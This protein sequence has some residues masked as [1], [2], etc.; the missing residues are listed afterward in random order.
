MKRKTVLLLASVLTISLTGCG[1]PLII[2][3]AT[4]AVDSSVSDSAATEADQNTASQQ[5]SAG[6]AAIIGQLTNQSDESEE[7]EEETSEDNVYTKNLVPSANKDVIDLIPY[8]I[9]ALDP[10]HDEETDT[11]QLRINEDSRDHEIS[12]LRFWI[13]G[14][15]ND[16]VYDANEYDTLR[17][18]Y[19]CDLNFT[20]NL[21]NIITVFTSSRTGRHQ[22]TVYSFEDDTVKLIDS[23][24]GFIDF[25]SVDGAGEFSITEATDIKTSTYGTMYVRKNFQTSQTTDYEAGVNTQEL[26]LESNSIGYYP[27]EGHFAIGYPFS[28]KNELTLYVNSEESYETGTLPINFRGV[29]KEAIIED[30]QVPNVFLV[31]PEEGWS[32]SE[33]NID[34]PIYA[35]SSAGSEDYNPENYTGWISYTELSDVAN[36]GFYVETQQ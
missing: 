32:D 26:V 2:E 22:T 18:V 30:K 29:I 16:F 21:S 19:V 9:Q 6:A 34:S 27:E 4:E 36:E 23:F 28:L 24:D 5:T 33:T 7:S 25:L 13:D 3:D 31:E 1:E 20:D 17:G 12:G 14:T 35:P 15:I 11:I 8:D 10:D